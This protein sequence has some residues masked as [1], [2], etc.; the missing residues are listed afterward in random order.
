[1]KNL[2]RSV[3]YQRK[4]DVKGVEVDRVEGHGE[5]QCHLPLGAAGVSSTKKANGYWRTVYRTAT[6]QQNSRS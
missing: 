2:L 3:V 1:M 4:G 5:G 6:M